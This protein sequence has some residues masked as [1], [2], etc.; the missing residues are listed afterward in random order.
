MI[1][2]QKRSEFQILPNYIPGLQ[3]LI[4]L[5]CWVTWWVIEF[6]YTYASNT[7][8]PASACVIVKIYAFIQSGIAQFKKNRETLQT[9]ILYQFSTF[10]LDNFH[11]VVLRHVSVSAWDFVSN[12]TEVLLK[13]HYILFLKRQEWLISQSYPDTVMF[14][15]DN[16]IELGT[17]DLFPLVHTK[18]VGIPPKWQHDIILACWI[19]A[20]P[21][22]K[23]GHS[24][25]QTCYIGPAFQFSQG[26]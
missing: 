26:R 10:E 20:T 11:K 16:S 25:G 8:H 24:E 23:H 12:L 1:R 18:C 3:V 21:L 4:P 15:V 14:A 6:L 19:S 17:V 2:S 22:C 13:H 9:D 7:H 5:I